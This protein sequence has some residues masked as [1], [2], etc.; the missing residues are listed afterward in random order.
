MVLYVKIFFC[1][2]VS[3]K[4]K[5]LIP[6]YNDG[7]WTV[8]KVQGI[9]NKYGNGKSP[10]TAA[11]YLKVSKDTGVPIDLLLAQGIQESS[12]GTAGRAVRT[13]NVGNVGNTDNGAESHNDS[14]LSGLYRQANLLKKEYGV[15]SQADVQRLVSNNFTRPVKGGNYASDSNYGYKIGKLLN[16]L[17]GKDFY[18]YSQFTTEGEASPRSY[19]PMDVKW[20]EDMIASGTVDFNKVYS[21]IQ[22]RPELLPMLN[23]GSQEWYKENQK[24]AL[25]AAEKEKKKA[26]YDELSNNIKAQIAYNEEK[27][28]RTLGLMYNAKYAKEDPSDSIT[29]YRTGG[30]LT[31]LDSDVVNFYREASSLFP[32][33]RITS[34]LRKG[35]RTKQGRVSR[36]ALGQAIDIAPHSGFHRYLYSSEGDALMRKYNLGLFDE[37]ISSNLYAT[38]GTGPHFHIGKDFKGNADIRN[39]AFKRISSIGMTEDKQSGSVVTDYYGGMNRKEFL[40]Y[41]PTSILTRD[42]QTFS[43]LTNAI[44]EEGDKQSSD[45]EKERSVQEQ[46]QELYNSKEEHRRQILSM[47]PMAK[48]SKSSY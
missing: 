43:E 15:A 3:M 17:N 10:F 26:L 25:E 31:G 12:L 20:L 38:G 42:W 24:I 40:P 39:T 5:H 19:T 2:F 4:L 1:I 28:N 22:K 29:E 37:T 23:H 33:I 46:V 21:F 45:A 32:D 18:K 6:K 9:I 8:S 27:R 47:I 13:K 11:D 14:W 41:I 30:M 35:A 34:G 36:H 48:Y 16:E 7:G 44:K